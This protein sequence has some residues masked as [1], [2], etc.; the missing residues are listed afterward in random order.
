MKLDD[1]ALEFQEA[2]DYF[3]GKVNLPTKAW[4]DVWEE[5]HTKAFVIAG[6]TKTTMLE[7]F[8][9]AITKAIENGT[10]LEEFRQDFDTI[11][12]KH[13]WTYKGK[14]GWRT[15][16]I[17]ETNLRTAH[18][19]GRW[20][21]IERVKKIRPYLR[22]IAVDDQRTRRQHKGWDG[23]IYPVDHEFWNTH[24][25]PNG[26]G[27]RCTVQS[28]SERDLKKKG[29]SVSSSMP[30]DGVDHHTI[31]TP[32]GDMQVETPAGI[33]PG[34]A[35]NVGRNR[36]TG[37]TPPPAP[38]QPDPGN[39]LPATTPMPSPRNVSTAKTLPSSGMT[40]DDYA[41][42]FLKEFGGSTSKPVLFTDKVGEVLSI[43]EDLFKD[44]N[45]DWKITKGG[46]APYLRYLADNIKD[47]DE[48]WFDWQQL[49][50]GKWV[51]RRRYMSRFDVSGK[52]LSGYSV[53]EV[54]NKGWREVTNFT[55]KADRKSQNQDE[56]LEKWR[57]GSL[58]YRKK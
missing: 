1:T 23:L 24:Y 51:L 43:S 55:P 42:A 14:R 57:R 2:I 36:L 7:D 41:D 25:P 33:D 20:D 47:P 40:E 11:V 15:R 21:Q 31:K 46:R 18:A 35:Y 9:G 17:F 19:A 28:L 3:K 8:R 58:L 12:A 48:I 37:V 10:T 52:Q 38:G 29:Y 22:Y 50:N 13:G 4:T 54:T 49:E 6:A 5:Q 53:F 26:W 32:G 27:C 30:A 16:V 44:I 39:G 45:G 56:Y 34:F